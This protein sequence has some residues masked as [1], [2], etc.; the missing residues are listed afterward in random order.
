MLCDATPRLTIAME[1]SG[2]TDPP[3]FRVGKKWTVH[4]L[5]QEN[6]LEPFLEIV[7]SMEAGA[8]SGGEALLSRITALAGAPEVTLYVAPQCPYCPGAIRQILPLVLSHPRAKAVLVD[9]ALFPEMAAVHQVRAVPTLILREGIRLT[10]EIRLATV[11]D[12]LEQDDP[13]HWTPEAL[14]RMLKEGQAGDLARMMIE[15]DLLF[16]AFF[17]LLSHAEWSVRLGAMVVLETIAA[18]RPELARSALQTLWND[19]PHH[20]APIRGDLLSLF[21]ELGDSTWIPALKDWL[22]VEE[23]DSVREVVGEVLAGWER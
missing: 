18:E 11:L 10:G 15:K 19:L 14:K 9:A 1:E 23:D 12:L 6:E 3:A 5:P 8:I 21:G 17:P 13:A 7:E 16:P 4:A 20:S 2:T 22:S